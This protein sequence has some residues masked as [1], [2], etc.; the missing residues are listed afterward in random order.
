MRREFTGWHMLAVLVGGFGVV[1]AV[2]LYM[3]SVAIGSFSGVVVPNSYVASQNYNRWL[4]EARAQQALG[5]Q[6]QLQ[7][8]DDGRL[9]VLTRSVPADAHIEAEARRALGDADWQ[10]I[11]FEPAS[12][13]RW[14]SLSPIGAGRWKVRLFLQ[15]E[16]EE[17]ASEEDLP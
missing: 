12:E 11:V 13:G 7:R 8:L 3:A 5:W 14:V 10:Q 16:G 15:H 6:A 4:A 1:I 17:W 2:N 9:E